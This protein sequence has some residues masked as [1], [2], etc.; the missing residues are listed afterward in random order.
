MAETK[1]INLDV[2]TNIGS[3]KAQ[4]QAAQREVYSMSEAFG[5]TSKQAAEA[6]IKAA[7][8]KDAIED[9]KNL[10][11]AFNP[12]AK[13]NALS[14]SIGGVLN[15][16]QAFEGA[17]GLLGVE[18]E[19]LQKTLL[20][21]QSAMALSQGIQ[22]LLEAKDSFVQLGAVAKNALSGIR[23]GIAATGIGLLVVALGTIVAYWDDIKSAVSGVSAEQAKLNEQT[24][25]NLLAQKAKYDAISGQDNILKLQGKSEREILKIKQTQIQAVI[26]A[27]EAQLVQQEITKK[28]QVAAAKRNREILE[29]M[30]T[31]ITAPLQFVLK[32]I[33]LAGKALGKDFGLQKGLTKGLATLV[34]DP[35]EV[36]EK[37]DETIKETKNKLAQLKNEAAGFT[38]A[39][40]EIDKPATEE[41]KKE[42]KKVEKEVEEMEI[43]KLNS[44]RTISSQIQEQRRKELEAE[45]ANSLEKRRI[46]K[47]EADAIIALE[48]KK[49]KAR[50]DALTATAATLGQIADLFGQQTAAGKAAAIAEATIQTYLSA[51]KA[52]QS[53]VGIPIVGPVLAPINAGLAIAAGIKNIKAITAVKTPDG[54]GGG[55]GN[56][57]NS[58]TSGAQAPSFNVVGNSGMNQ[59]AQIQQ[60]P[61]Q[62]YVVSGEVT[63]AQALDRNRVKNATL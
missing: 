30:I 58:F 42:A 60:T 10:T 3:L 7:S 61:I 38:L 5:A 35:E 19:E 25:A 36:K 1:T 57:T 8:L 63:S 43:F 40:K 33:D 52:Y 46:A 34:F 50:E 4:L 16:F 54:G 15:G 2:K 20:K 62:A 23:A 48:E 9:A 24:D 32:T 18:S 27:T 45:M 39:I 55:G 59:L 17:M 37:A 49:K 14:S 31:F 13:F 11:D 47:E 26:K 28:A 12:D 56:V 21:V 53:T 51:Q 29:G 22:G 44:V 6:A 41:V